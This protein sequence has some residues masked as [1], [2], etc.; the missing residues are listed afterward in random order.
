MSEGLVATDLLELDNQSVEETFPAFWQRQGDACR[1]TENR[2]ERQCLLAD[3][4]RFQ[5]KIEQ[6]RDRFMAL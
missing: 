2:I 5:L 3:A 4:E 1:L 6:L